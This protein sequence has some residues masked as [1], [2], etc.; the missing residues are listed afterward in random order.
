ML[1]KKKI[2]NTLFVLSF[3]WYGYG[4]YNLAHKGFAIGIF[5][6]AIPFVLIL[7]IYMLDLLYRKSMTPLVNGKFYLV[8]GALTSLSISVLVGLITRVR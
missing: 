6:C 2:I 3:P 5:T 1:S 8:M 4:A 7:G